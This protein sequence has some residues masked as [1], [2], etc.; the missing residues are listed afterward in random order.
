MFSLQVRNARGRYPTR[1]ISF[2]SLTFNACSAGLFP[3]ELSHDSSFANRSECVVVVD[4]IVTSSVVP[5]P[6]AATANP[7]RRNSATPSAAA[8]NSEAAQTRA[9]CV[10]PF[11]SVNETVQRRLDTVSL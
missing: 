8:S 3:D 6:G 10:M 1:S 5:T 2:R 7:Q 4:W 11:E 9:K